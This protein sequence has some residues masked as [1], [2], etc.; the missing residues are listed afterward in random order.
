MADDTKP[1]MA[2]NHSNEM[3]TVKFSNQRTKMLDTESLC[4]DD[5]PP[6][7]SAHILESCLSEFNTSGAQG[8]DEVSDAGHMTGK[9]SHGSVKVNES[10]NGNGV[11]RYAL[12]MRF[13]CPHPKRMSRS[14]QRYQSDPSSKTE[15]ERRFYLYSDLKVVFPQRHSDSDEGK[16]WIISQ[17]FVTLFP[18]IFFHCVI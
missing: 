4:H 14:V 13:V 8:S 10:S 18:R 12:H 11:L 1:L 17:Y 16:V 2:Q 6:V 15:A 9:V 7:E 3:T 5:Y